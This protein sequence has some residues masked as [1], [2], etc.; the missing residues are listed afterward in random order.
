MYFFSH[1]PKTAGT[2]LGFI[3]EYMFNRETFWD[4]KEKYAPDEELCAHLRYFVNKNYIS[5]IGGH[6]SANQYKPLLAGT[7]IIYL[8]TARHPFSHFISKLN[9][10]FQL[11][12]CNTSAD[13]KI[14]LQDE[15]ITDKSNGTYSI[16]IA[17]VRDFFGIDSIFAIP[18]MRNYLKAYIEINGETPGDRVY[19]FLT[20]SLDISLQYFMWNEARHG[21]SLIRKDPAIINPGFNVENSSREAI[22]HCMPVLNSAETRKYKLVLTKN[23][24]EKISSFLEDSIRYYETIKTRHSNDIIQAS[25]DGFSPVKSKSCAFAPLQS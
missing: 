2:S 9:H 5:F 10:D 12:I 23:D 1:I 4:Y 6:I 20:D 19:P 16:P 8:F 11:A 25:D 21:I 7:D 14:K 3:F 15:S 17:K 13:V 22:K 24:K 18:S